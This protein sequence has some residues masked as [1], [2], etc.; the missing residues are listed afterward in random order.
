[1]AAEPQVNGQSVGLTISGVLQG[2]QACQFWLGGYV[3]SLLFTDLNPPPPTTTTVAVVRAPPDQPDIIGQVVTTALDPQ[4]VAVVRAP[5]DQPDIT[6][7][8]VTTDYLQWSDLTFG[9]F[10]EISDKDVI[11]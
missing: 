2:R 7:Q 10:P 6:G 3:C 1:M 5:P 9:I 8:V 4:T 11:I